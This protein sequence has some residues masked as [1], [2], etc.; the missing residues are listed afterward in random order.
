MH[1]IE[2]GPVEKE[3]NMLP[4]YIGMVVA[5]LFWGIAWTIGK[6]AV[7][8]ANPQVAAFWRYLFAFLPIIP[9]IWW[10]KSSLKTDAKGLMLTLSAAA[11]TAVFNYLFFLG[12]LHGQA[13]YGGT[14]VTAL[15][16]IFTYFISILFLGVRVSPIQVAALLIGISGTVIFLR[17]PWEGLGFLNADSLY[18]LEAALDWAFV[19]VISQKASKRIDIFVYTMIVFGV[20][21]LI[22][23]FFALP[24][25]PFD[26]AAYDATF[27][28]AIIFMGVLPGTFST[29]LFFLSAGKIGAH[30]TGAFMF[31]VPVGAIVSSWIVY[32]EHIE[33]STVVGAAL[34]FATVILF[35]AK[36]KTAQKP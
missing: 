22:N 5:M 14:L 11:L 30:R 18:F 32:N 8:H 36:R 10:R 16:P 4:Y 25:H 27:W 24:Y 28:Y 1:N 3:A 26:F 20:T 34:A 15:A 2:R 17:I 31:L 29:A 13:G 23:L 9:I 33:L 6:I 12:L 35:N 21:A 19:T 7:E